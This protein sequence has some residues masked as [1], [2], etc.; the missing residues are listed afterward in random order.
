MVSAFIPV[1]TEDPGYSALT[2]QKFDWWYSVYGY[3]KYLLP[4]Y[5]PTP[6]INYVIL[7]HYVDAEL[8]HGQLTG[9][10]VK[11]IIN[12]VNK[13]PVDLYYKKHSTM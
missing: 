11:G 6:L 5:E 13:N 12:F 2:D 4:Y 7:K 3:V 8:F 9:F 10:S 1:C